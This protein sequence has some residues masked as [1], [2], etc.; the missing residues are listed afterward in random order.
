MGRPGLRDSEDPIHV[1]LLKRYQ[2]GQNYPRGCPT[3]SATLPGTWSWRTQASKVLCGHYHDFVFFS[4]PCVAM[5]SR[6]TMLLCFGFVSAN[7][8]TNLCCGH[9]I[10][11]KQHMSRCLRGWQSGLLG[12]TKIMAEF[13]R[14]ICWTDCTLS[15]IWLFSDSINK[16]SVRQS[17]ITSIFAGFAV[18]FRRMTKIFNLSGNILFMMGWWQ[19]HHFFQWRILEVLPLP[20]HSHPHPWHSLHLLLPTM[21]SKPTS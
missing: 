16:S 4:E 3:C 9:V 10:L 15:S 6:W 21:I 7:V 13:Q 17:H 2:S 12:H 8:F 14:P 20:V 1:V 5:T 19:W 18:A 11:H